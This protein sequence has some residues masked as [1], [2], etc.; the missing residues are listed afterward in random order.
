[1]NRKTL[2]IGAIWLVIIALLA[3]FAYILSSHKSH[4]AYLPTAVLLVTPAT[5]T[6]LTGASVPVDIVV[7]SPNDAALV[8]GVRLNYSSNLQFVS[9]DPSTTLFTLPI[10]PATA[11]GGVV[12][13]IYT[14]VD[15]GYTGT[16]GEVVHLNFTALSAG[17]ASI[18]IDQTNS[19]VVTFGMNQSLASVQNAAITINNPQI[20]LKLLLPGRSSEAQTGI[21]TILYP[22]GSTTPLVTVPNL[23]TAA[24]GTITFAPGQVVDATSYDMRITVPGYL[25]AKFTGLTH[26]ITLSQNLTAQPLI[27]GDFDGN[28][29]IDLTDILAAIRAFNGATDTNAVAA[30]QTF[31]GSVS[32]L[33]LV[34][35]IRNYNLSPTGN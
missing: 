32:I 26:L 19:Q 20:S 7:N 6:V 27:P 13:L 29:K 21:S 17:P 15:S 24:D 5:Q 22:A 35:V 3:V 18:T 25:T 28:N 31:G 8:V 14:R 2:Y 10:T 23:S 9:A 12:N 1:M 4:A 33:N 16:G 30:K 34:T 11:S